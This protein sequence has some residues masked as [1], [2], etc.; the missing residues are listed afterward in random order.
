MEKETTKQLG[1]FLC[2]IVAMMVVIGLTV[3]NLNDSEEESDIHYG[4][5]E[6]VIINYDGTFLVMGNGDI[7]HIDNP[8]E[9][10]SDPL[11]TGTQILYVESMIIGNVGN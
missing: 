9:L 3:T 10:T 5:V 8:E 1:I 4:T 7:V 2:F 11:I 6:D